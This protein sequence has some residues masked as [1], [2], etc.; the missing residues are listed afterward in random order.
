LFWGSLRA[1]L[2]GRVLWGVELLGDDKAPDGQLVN[3][4]PSDPRA[5]DC[6]SADGKCTEGY[7]ADCNCAQRKPAHR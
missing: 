5:A 6:Q 4:Q 1:R 2:I 3:F 7:G